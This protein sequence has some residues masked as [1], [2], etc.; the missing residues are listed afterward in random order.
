MTEKRLEKLF[1]FQ[2]FQNNPRLASLIAETESR[3]EE[4]LSDEILEEVSAAGETDFGR[5]AFL[6]LEDNDHD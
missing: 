3:Y 2:R 6:F 5:K 4:A 1:D